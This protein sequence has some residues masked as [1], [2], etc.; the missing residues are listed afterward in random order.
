MILIHD[1]LIIRKI[2]GI[3]LDFQQN[4]FVSR[5]FQ[6]RCNHGLVTCHIYSKRYQ[7]RRNI[8]LIEGSGHTVFSSDGRQSKSELCI[9]CTKQ[10]QER[11][12]PSCRIFGHTTEVLLES[13]T[14]LAEIS[15]A[16]NDT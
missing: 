5:F 14:D 11:L 13:E 7:C 16:C 2:I 8:D 12:A 10:C 9:V 6:F 1:L 15:A 3:T 4:Q